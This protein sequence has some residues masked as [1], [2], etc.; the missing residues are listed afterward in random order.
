MDD[1]VVSEG[2]LFL[3][4]LKPAW[5]ESQVCDEGRL[6]SGILGTEGKPPPKAAA[7]TA[8]FGGKFP[9]KLRCTVEMRPNPVLLRV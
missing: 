3:V 1:S 4:P 7:P 6:G 9:C 5:V 8:I 2:G